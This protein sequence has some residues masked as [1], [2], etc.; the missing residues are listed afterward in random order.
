MPEK[1]TKMALAV[2]GGKVSISPPIWPDREL[3]VQPGDLSQIVPYGNGIYGY[4]DHEGKDPFK[5]APSQEA[6]GGVMYF[7]N[8]VSREDFEALM[9]ILGVQPAHRVNPSKDFAVFTAESERPG[10]DGYLAQMRVVSK[11]GLRYMFNALDN[12]EYEEFPEQE[13]TMVE[14]LWSFIEYECGRW[15]TSFSQD[16]QNGLRGLFGGDGDYAREELSF[17]FMVENDYHSVYRIWSRA[18]LVTK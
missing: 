18:W 16:G 5:S 4:Q 12:S 3:K 6:S 10:E 8:R 13:L 11:F 2:R 15:G 17:G 9:R 14:A 1:P 7:D